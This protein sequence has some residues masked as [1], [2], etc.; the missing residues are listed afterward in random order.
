MD[1]AR[2]F[3]KIV[4]DIF[5]LDGGNRKFD[6]RSGGRQAW[7]EKVNRVRLRDIT[8][9][10]LQKWKVEFLKGRGSDPIRRRSGST[11]VNSLLRQAK[12]LFA[13]GILRF[14]HLDIAS[15]PFEGVTFEPRKSMRYQST[16]N[17][18]N[19][20]RSG[21]EELSEEQF[22]VFLLAI[23]AGL[24]RNEIDK[25]EWRAFDWEE[26]LISIRATPFFSP[27]SEDSTGTVE[28]DPKKKE[29][30]VKRQQALSARQMQLDKLTLSVLSNLED[31]DSDNQLPGLI[32]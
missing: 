8:P 12:S 9:E 23:M 17:L 25:L 30:W 14:L 29:T 21:R 16:F 5:G 11:S 3:R 26:G 1:Y 10:K 18:E 20:I 31:E 2:A 15:S 6:Y 19:V 28:I 27:K 22:K 24:R 32:G 7:V 13:P 4:S